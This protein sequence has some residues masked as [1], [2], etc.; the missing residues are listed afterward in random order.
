M[1]LET[2]LDPRVWDAVRESYEARNFTNAIL[3][4]MYFLSDLLRERTG[5]ESDGVALVG[6]AFGGSSPKLKVNALQ[7]ES[8]KSVQKGV[9][10]LL[11]G[12]YQAVRNPR[13]HGKINDTEDDSQAIV[14]FINY[15]VKLIS[16]S[17]A[18][19]SKTAFVARVFDPDFVANGRYAELLV[20]EIPPKKRLEVFFDVYRSKC[21]GKGESLRFFFDALLA[22]LQDEEKQSVYQTISKELQQTDDETTII[23]MIQAFD[24]K[25]WL[26]LDE[27]ARL[28]IENKLIRSIKAGHYISATNKCRGGVLGTWSTRLFPHFS[29]KS[30]ALWAIYLKLLSSDRAEQDYVFKYLLFAMDS[31]TDTPPKYLEELLIK[32]ITAGDVRFFEAVNRWYLW[33]D[34]KWSSELKTALE[35]F[36]EAEPTPEY[37]DEDIPF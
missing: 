19:F 36:Q 21:D 5:L 23:V 34:E 13:S 31:L 11:R 20:K 10:Q 3:D 29:L 6:E 35:R 25:L 33:E 16:E 37:S 15:L 14:L 22:T 1:N 2:K 32:G 27:T 9:E 26:Q 7:S 17:K 24:P 18:P 28:R 4:A 30:D 8:D 12:I